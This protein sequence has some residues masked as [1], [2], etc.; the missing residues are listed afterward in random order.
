MQCNTVWSF[1]FNIHS[2]GTTFEN[3][4]EYDIRFSMWINKRQ[5][6]Q[7]DGR[8]LLNGPY[9]TNLLHKTHTINDSN[10]LLF[11][12]SPVNATSD[13]CDKHSEEP[14]KMTGVI[15][16]ERRWMMI[17][18]EI[19][20]DEYEN[21]NASTQESNLQEGAITRKMEAQNINLL[22][23]IWENIKAWLITKR[24]QN[25]QSTGL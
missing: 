1:C 5:R 22:Y 2:I 12:R 13:R 7:S 9:E 10:N 8:F 25:Y 18:I 19:H 3:K 14:K 20:V 24:N 17:I 21:K 16:P 15:T 6:T 11:Q 4:M 23:Q